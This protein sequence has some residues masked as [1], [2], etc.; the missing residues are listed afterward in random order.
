M[1]GSS[2]LILMLSGRINFVRGLKLTNQIVSFGR[3]LTF[4]WLVDNPV[5]IYLPRDYN[6]EVFQPVYP[7]T[8]NR[9]ALLTNLEA[10]IARVL[11]TLIE[12]RLLLE[13]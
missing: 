4:D 10:F 8:T 12:L 2:Y 7:E 5:R 11:R 1:P 6:R 3:K 13:S 9:T